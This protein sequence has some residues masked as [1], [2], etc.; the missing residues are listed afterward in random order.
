[1]SGNRWN[2][3][4]LDA[5]AAALPDEGI[6]LRS[7]LTEQ[8]GEAVFAP[9][10]GDFAKWMAAEH[11]EVKIESTEAAHLA[12]HSNDVWLPLVALGADVTVQSFLGIVS[13]YLYDRFRGALSRSKLPTVSLSIE[14]QEDAG[15]RVKRL[16]F[17][18]DHE[19]LNAVPRRLEWMSMPGLEGSDYRQ[20]GFA[21]ASASACVSVERTGSQV[22]SVEALDWDP[23]FRCRYARASACAGACEPVSTD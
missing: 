10:A 6:A 14:F 17:S 16:S 15:G 23:L 11:S 18:G 12:L 1:M 13:N 20:N 2:F 3:T 7:E 9:D 19:S 8:A 22:S 5:A 4:D 21:S